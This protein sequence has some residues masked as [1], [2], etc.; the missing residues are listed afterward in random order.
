MALQVTTKLAKQ[1]LFYTKLKHIIYCTSRNS[2]LS[3]HFHCLISQTEIIYATNLAHY[4]LC[5]LIY[6][7]Y[8]ILSLCWHKKWFFLEETVVIYSLM[9]QPSWNL[10]KGSCFAD[11]KFNSYLWIRKTIY[12]STTIIT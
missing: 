9:F 12:G 10:Q 5:H 8:L 2:L 11:F 4:V 7:W 1:S 3:N 6:Y